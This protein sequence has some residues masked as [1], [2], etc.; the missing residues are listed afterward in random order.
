[1][2]M[3]QFLAKRSEQKEAQG[4]WAQLRHFRVPPP[5]GWAAGEEGEW[6]NCNYFGGM[7][8]IGHNEERFGQRKAGTLGHNQR[9]GD[10]IYSRKDFKN[11]FDQTFFE[12]QFS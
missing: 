10:S 8:A 11:I 12:N 6:G 9:W 5:I 4:G 3:H 7:C 1:M 2:E